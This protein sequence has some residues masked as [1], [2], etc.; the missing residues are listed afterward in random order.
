MF[1]FTNNR[2]TNAFADLE[3][4]LRTLGD[5]GPRSH[6]RDGPRPPS[7][8]V[9]VRRERNCTR[10]NQ[11]HTCRGSELRRNGRIGRT[12]EQVAQTERRPEQPVRRRESAPQQETKLPSCSEEERLDRRPAHPERDRELVIGKARELAENECLALLPRQLGNRQAQRLDVRSPDGCVEGV[13]STR[14]LVLSGGQWV[15][16]PLLRAGTA[17]VSCDRRE[18]GGRLTRVIAGEQAAIGR[19]E[20]LLGRVLSVVRIPQQAAAETEHER[21]VLVEEP[22]EPDGRPRER[23]APGRYGLSCASRRPHHC[24]RHPGC[25]HPGHRR[26]RS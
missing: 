12:R 15:A 3:A 20:R 18:P 8:V 11:H 16:H 19:Q 26:L 17:L 5:S 13:V 21:R 24:R 25:H 9:A 4:Q 6:R 10:R 22:A 1:N 7:V 2:S 23:A 14:Q